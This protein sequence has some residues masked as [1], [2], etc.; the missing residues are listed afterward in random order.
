[1]KNK[2]GEERDDGAEK[3]LWFKKIE[4]LSK[5]T[6][7]KAWNK[8]REKDSRMMVK[9]SRFQVFIFYFH[10]HHI[11]I[12]KSLSNST[13]ASN[14][15]CWSNFPH[16]LKNVDVL[17]ASTLDSLSSLWPKYESRIVLSH[18]KMYIKQRFPKELLQR[19]LIEWSNKER[20][21]LD[22]DTIFVMGAYKM[23][24]HRIATGTTIGYQQWSHFW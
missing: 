21:T 16:F 5:P 20:R 4:V 13:Y 2:A 15:S 24:P 7:G 6:D 23:L 18:N 22:I 10:V 12:Q 17:E 11:S 1:M 19:M 9:C 8:E 3:L 14:K